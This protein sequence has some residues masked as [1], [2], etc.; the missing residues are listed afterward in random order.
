LSDSEK[1]NFIA[2]KKR[3]FG[4]RKKWLFRG[5][6]K[7]QFFGNSKKGSHE[8]IAFSSLPEKIDFS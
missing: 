7:Y 2:L 4:Y 8:K 6:L 5:E 1:K 3:F